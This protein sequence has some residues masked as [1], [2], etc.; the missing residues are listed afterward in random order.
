MKKQNSIIALIL[1]LALSLAFISGC[2]SKVPS[3]LSPSPIT[4]PAKSDHNSMPYLYEPTPSVAQENA[5]GYWEAPAPEQSQDYELF[6]APQ[7]D[8]RNVPDYNNE[9]YS[10]A[11][12][13]PF[14]DVSAYP[15]STFSADVDTAS[16]SNMRRYIT[17][18]MAPVGVRIEELVNYFDY[19]YP[20]PK[21]GDEHPFSI[22][23]EI[24]LCPWEPEHMLAMIGIQAATLR[25]SKEIANNIVFLIDVSGSMSDYN[26]LP[27]V[28]ESMKLMFEQLGENDII[29]IVT[30]AGSDRVIADSIRGSE[31][32]KL[33]KLADRLTAGGS[34][35]GARGLT[36]AYE[37]AT[38]NY[39]EGGNN[40]VILATDGD[41]NVGV[42]SVEGLTRL[43]E[44]KRESGIFISVL[45]Y[46]MYNLKDDMMEA[47]ADN[48]NGNYAYIDTIE[49]AKK[50]LVDEFDS[51]MF[52]IAKD[53]KLQ[54]EFNPDTIG[55]Y[56]LIG[57]DTRRLRNEDFN[58]DLKD[59]GDI[60]AGHS[61]TAFYELVP[62][63]RNRNETTV[64][65]LRYSHTFTTG[66][67]EFL[68]VSVR[69]K[70]PNGYESK[71][72]EHVAGA[73]ALKR[74]ES[75]NYAF[76]SAVVEFGLIITGSRYA[77]YTTLSSVMSRAGN[78]LGSD[79]YGLRSEF[80][81]LVKQYGRIAPR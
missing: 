1:T 26:K 80:L 19:A 14:I 18:G 13:S 67:D 40:R 22:T 69:Y 15:L 81:E 62:A 72:V 74:R 57:Y 49:E 51:T 3:S 70:D 36:T 21:P 5:D 16:Y 7:E 6:R 56:R 63:G 71:L 46:G 59:A 37:L 11:T 58:N 77:D 33:N 66:S 61:V 50:V 30:Y 76:A 4:A 2:S 44:Q 54:V 42:S 39:I 34:T 60:G 55:S 79:T 75:D 41:F 73:E 28:V 25:N 27:L 31:T 43:I 23:T 64:N 9:E 45:G 10:A 24:G 78:A 68:N 29:S 35:A 38:K 12:E 17:Q 65:P 32:Q 47:I 8:W 53:V 48:G 52:T 20:A